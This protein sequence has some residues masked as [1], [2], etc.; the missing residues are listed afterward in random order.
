MRPA[1]E[2]NLRLASMVHG[3]HGFERIVWAFRNILNQ[4]VTWLF[5]NVNGANDGSGPIAPHQPKIKNVEP[6]TESLNGICVP[7]PSRDIQEDDPDLA[8]DLLEWLSLAAMASPRIHRLDNIDT[9]L[10][11]YQVPGPVDSECSTQ[12]ITKLH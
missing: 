5:Y 12:D 7:Q 8:N 10:S 1:I 9:H 3:K 11:R 2:L 6:Q 4:S